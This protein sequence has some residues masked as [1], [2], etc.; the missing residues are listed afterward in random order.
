MPEAPRQEIK[1]FYCYARV[2]KAL[3]DELEKHLSNLKRQYRLNTWHDRVILPG[4][5]WEQAIDKNLNTSHLVL[6]LISPD[7]M[8]SDYCYNKEMTK[9]LERERKGLCRIIP[10]LLRPT[11]WEGAP[12]SH[13]QML[14]TDTR[15]VT[16]WPDHDQAFWDIAI[17]IR[18]VLK[19]FLLTLETPGR[20]VEEADTFISH[21]PQEQVLTNAPV[22]TLDEKRNISIIDLSIEA[23][24]KIGA[25]KHP[26]SL[27][28]LHNAYL[29]ANPDVTK[30]I[31][32]SSFDAT[33]NYHTINM[34]SRFFYPDDKRKLAQW[35][36]RPVF[37]RVA[38]AQYML[39]SPDEIA[40]F[41]QRVEEEDQRIYQDE[42]A[43]EDLA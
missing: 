28:D 16:S 5:D 15:P 11:D 9:A 39:L 21:H 8:A 14:P 10:I 3:R 12:F 1:L 38:R 34:R 22:S 4:E 2:D 43:V 17:G 18:M 32:R 41:R 30:G 35:L 26:I 13:L 36:S 37:K 31:T 40:L 20:K 33:I 27:A 19:D 6:L 23:A 25:D 42:Y 7:F 24:L 29:R